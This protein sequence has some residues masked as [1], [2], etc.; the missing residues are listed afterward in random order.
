[1]HAYLEA[2]AT[3][4]GNKKGS[5]GALVTGKLYNEHL[6]GFMPENIICLKSMISKA[7]TQTTTLKRKTSSTTKAMS[8]CYTFRPKPSAKPLNSV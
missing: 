5:A 7:T 2:A 1:L 3:A 8:S 4:A 6:V